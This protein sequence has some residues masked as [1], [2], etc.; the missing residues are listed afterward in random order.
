MIV[1]P[2]HTGINYHYTQ[3]VSLICPHTKIEIVLLTVQLVKQ[4]LRLF[5]FFIALYDTCIDGCGLNNTAHRECLPSNT[6]LAT[7]GRPD[8][9]NKRVLMLKW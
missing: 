7:E 9:C 8:G 2:Q 1:K 3:G 6:V 5:L 4:V